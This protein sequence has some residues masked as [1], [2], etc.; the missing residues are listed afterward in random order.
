MPAFFI[1]VSVY[2]KRR[3][4]LVHLLSK[5]DV[6]CDTLSPLVFTGASVAVVVVGGAYTCAVLTSSII[7]C[8]GYNFYG[9]LGTGDTTDRSTP[10]AMTGLTAAVCAPCTV[11]CPAGQYLSGCAGTSIGSCTACSTSCPAG[12]Y[13]SGCVGTSAGSCVACSTSCPAGQYLSGCGNGTS[14][15]SC[16]ACSTSCPA[17]QHLNGCLG[18][19]PGTC[20]TCADGSYLLA[21]ATLQ[22]AVL[23]TIPHTYVDPSNCQKR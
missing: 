7:D 3:Y 11:S 5:V 12:L 22:L 21:G 19:S 9:Q 17:G 2:E 23:S 10:T 18:L 20:T 1:F 4:I 13:L 6:P 15:G 16:T 8:W 14:K